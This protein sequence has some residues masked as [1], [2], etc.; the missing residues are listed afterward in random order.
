MD[1]IA[2]EIA[3]RVHPA[4]ERRG[5]AVFVLALILALSVLA[6]AWMRGAYWGLFAFLVLFLSLESFFLVS[7]YALGPE[8][9]RVERAFSRSERAWSSFR[10]AWFDASGVTLSPFG[11]RHWLETYRAV[12]LRY[13]RT[14]GAPTREAVNEHLLA[15]LDPAQVQIHGPRPVADANPLRSD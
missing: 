12:R 7:R 15:H 9:V 6:A 5:M 3:W 14:P 11:R 1:P 10:S 8:G 2:A 4:A 13:G